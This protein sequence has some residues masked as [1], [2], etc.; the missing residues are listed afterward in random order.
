MLVVAEIFG[1][2]KCSLPNPETG[3]RWLIHLAEQHDHILQ[4]P[5]FFHVAVEFFPFTAT[6]A[7][8]TKDIKFTEH[9]N[10]SLSVERYGAA[11]LIGDSCVLHFA[12]SDTGIGIPEDK[13]RLIFEAFSQADSSIARRFGGTGLGLA[14]SSRLV[15]LMGGQIWVESTPEKGSTFH[16]TVQFALSRQ[17]TKPPLSMQLERLKNVPMLVV[18]D[19]ATNRRV[20]YNMLSQWQIKPVLASTAWEATVAATNAA[21][22]GTPF[23]IILVDYLMPEVD[24]ITLIQEM[25]DDP[26]LS[27][28]AF[29]LLSSSAGADVVARRREVDIDA[30]LQTP[31]Q[32]ADLLKVIS[33]VLNQ[34]QE[35]TADRSMQEGTGA[36]IL[37]SV[38][39]E[40]PIAERRQLHILL[41]EDNR[42]NQ[43]VAIHFL[44]NEGHRVTLAKN[45]H[46]AIAFNKKHQPDVILMDLQ[47]PD[48]DGLQATAAIRAE[49]AG[50]GKHV[51]IIAV[52]AYAMESDR[53][54]C[55]AG[56]MDGYVSKP[57]QLEELR[58]A[59]A[60]A[61]PVR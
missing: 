34:K 28:G 55:L 40:K 26:Q 22:Q 4:Y 23:P 14:I 1:H 13:Q 5:R 60:T 15:E 51:P 30:F 11:N 24:G 32:Q 33:A 47:M 45:G 39:E 17:E 20:V 42:I 12:V 16:F 36:T 18:D 48:M 27:T 49:E 38:P 10:V 53:N 57:I 6:L 29:I 35:T 56:G 41:A 43:Q 3:S 19:S 25:R 61:M 9:G 8:A 21:N 58:L 54:R 50:T 59:L 7:N 2:G 44:E 52:T 46:E 31:I 37:P